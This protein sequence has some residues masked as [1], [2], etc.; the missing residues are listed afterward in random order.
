MG[1][2]MQDKDNTALSCLIV[3]VSYNQAALFL[4]QMSAGQTIYINDPFLCYVN[5]GPY[6]IKNYKV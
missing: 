6:H 5:M 1:F 4:V 2:C 3:H